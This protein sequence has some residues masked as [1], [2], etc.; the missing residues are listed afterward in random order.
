M[1]TAVKKDVHSGHQEIEACLC[2]AREHVY[3]PSMNKELKA[4]IHTRETC[5]EYELT[6]CKETLMSHEIPDGAWEKIGAD[7][8]TYNDKEYLVTV[9]YK[10]NFWELDP[11]TDTK[12]STVIKRLKSHLARYGIP[13]Q[14]VRDN[15]PQ[16]TSREFRS[17]TKTWGIE[18]TNISPHHSQANGKVEL[19]VKT[20]KRMLHKTSKSGED[21]Y[22]ALL[23]IQNTPTQGVASSPAQCLLGRR[24]RSLLP[25]TRSLLEPRSPLS[26]YE[27]EQLQL[28][29][30]RQQHYYNR[31]SHDLP[32]LKGGDTV[33]MKQLGCDVTK[34]LDERSYEVQSHGSSFRRN[35]QHL[36]KS[37]SV[38][39]ADALPVP[40]PLPGP[41]QGQDTQLPNTR[42]A[43]GQKGHLEARTTKQLSPVCTRSGCVIKEPVRFQDYVKT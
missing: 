7:L 11:L 35:R 40:D 9:C 27:R 39:A 36:V 16:F 4:W 25:S 17:F 21:Q 43:N 31:S 22:L 42:A 33:R 32:A 37:P 24:T 30:K 28:N 41:Q 14:L 12:S 26:L 20:A 29:Q 1:C 23:N 18:H 8:F 19:A 13:R 3:W 15:G 5:R 2:R 10:S 34:R 38:P 6:P